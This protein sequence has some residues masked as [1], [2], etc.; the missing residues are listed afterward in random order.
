MAEVNF[1]GGISS[2]SG[3]TGPKTNP[4]QPSPE[5]GPSVSQ[6]L[7]ESLNDV[8]KL[9]FE[10]D[11]SVE[12]LVVGKSKNIHE[13]MIALNKADIAFRMTL[14]VRNKLVEAYQEIIRMQV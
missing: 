7:K 2:I 10:A 1:P 4:M 8:N 9:Q 12:D 6:L 11:K 3:L 5:A 14:Q 13:T